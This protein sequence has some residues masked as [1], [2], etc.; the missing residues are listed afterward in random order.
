[1]HSLY[2]H[3]GGYNSE[4]TLYE[5]LRTSTNLKM[6]RYSNSRDDHGIRFDCRTVEELQILV[7]TLKTLTK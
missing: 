5:R 7:L 2:F 1:M 4:E 3:T 6:T